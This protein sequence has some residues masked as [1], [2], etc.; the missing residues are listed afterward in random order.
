M[1]K[2]KIKPKYSLWQNIC[3]MFAFAWREQKGVIFTC[4]IPPF[5]TVMIRLTDIYIAPS[6][7]S[8]IEQGASLSALLYTIALF[9]ALTIVLRSAYSFVS[10]RVGYGRETLV[11]YVRVRLNEKIETTA[12]A[13]IDDSTILNKMYAALN[14]LY[15]Y[16][17]FWWKTGVSVTN[18]LGF[19]AYVVV[20]RSLNPMLMAVSVVTTLLSTYVTKRLNDWEYSL[21]SERATYDQTLNHVLTKAQDITA[22][23]DIRIFGMRDW[24]MGIYGRTIGLY[25]AFLLRQNKWFLLAKVLDTALYVIRNGVSYAYL[26]TMTIRHGWAASEFLLYFSAITDFINWVTAFLSGFTDLHQCSNHISEVRE[27]IELEEPFA[28]EEGEGLSLPVDGKC[29]IT[30]SGVSYRYPGADA[31]TL[32]D[33]N[34]TLHPG[35]KL[36][37]V[38]LN[39]AGKTT[40]VKVL[41]G[42]YDPTEGTVLLNGKDIRRYDRR[43]YYKYFSAVFQNYSLIEAT[44]AENIAQDVISPDMEKVKSCGALAGLEDMIERLPEGYDTPLG[45]RVNEN[46]IELS[47]GQTQRMLLA[48]ALYKGAPVLILDE[49]TAA[50]DPIAENEIYTGYNALCA[51]RSAVYISHRLASTRFCDLI[52]YLEDGR[53]A[54]QGSH[55]SLV[56]AGGKYAN[57]FD[58]QS[59]YYREEAKENG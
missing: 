11:H 36:A 46:G 22:A 14:S 8:H 19:F 57:L 5:L 1:K 9:S 30:L 21:N 59:K 38:G 37:V 28:F 52:V 34:L 50:L 53:I 18:F 39:G 2:E 44:V 51:Q 48:R 54:E 13:N 26:I 31:D 55:D 16:S 47:G 45:K 23:K 20:L 10:H 15:Y 12:Y 7:L 27:F 32:K 6:I 58:V 3:Y 40:L 41:C 29:E 49:P 42:M 17:T 33:I 56:K 4:L 43:D 24:L 35:E 25:R